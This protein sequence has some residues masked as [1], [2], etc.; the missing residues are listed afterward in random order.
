MASRVNSLWPSDTIWWQR[1]GSTLA[2]VMA[3]CLT[4]PSHY[5][6]QC[7]LIISKIKLHSSDSNFTSDN[8]AI[9]HWNK[10]EDHSSKI[11]V[12]SP[13]GQWVKMIITF[14]WG[15]WVKIW[16]DHCWI[17]LSFFQMC[18]ENFSDKESYVSHLLGVRHKGMKKRLLV[19]LS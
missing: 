5:L 15:E 6:N 16:Y 3:F 7:W 10:F 14:P 18:L 19:R 4:A 8:S 1:S 12:K 2:Q 13:R 11:S 17:F 9:N